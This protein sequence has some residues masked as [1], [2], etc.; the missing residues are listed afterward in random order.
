MSSRELFANSR[1]IHGP[2]PEQSQSGCRG[3]RSSVAGSLV[4]LPIKLQLR[5]ILSDPR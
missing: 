2:Q 5:P 1:Q 4:Q 3:I